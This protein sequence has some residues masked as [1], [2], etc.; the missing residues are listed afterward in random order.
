MSE[1][2]DIEELPEG[3]FPLSFNLV[4]RYQRKYPILTEKQ[5]CLEYATGSFHGVRSTR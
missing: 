5:T 1:L 4:Y 2:Y 3:M